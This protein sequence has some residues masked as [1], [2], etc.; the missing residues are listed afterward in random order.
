MKRCCLIIIR[1]QSK[2]CFFFLQTVL[3]VLQ[4]AIWQ[5]K[6]LIYPT[7]KQIPKIS[8]TPADAMSLAVLTSTCVKL[9]NLFAHCRRKIFYLAFA[10]FIFRENC[11]RCTQKSLFHFFEYIS[12]R[13]SMLKFH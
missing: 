12:E 4:V 7:L 1:F 8:R 11:L 10:M 6:H 9:F 5:K 3:T 13:A 2:I